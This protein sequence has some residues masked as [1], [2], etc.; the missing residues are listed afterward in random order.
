[1]A[2]QKTKSGFEFELDINRID[3]YELLEAVSE[4]EEDPLAVVRVLKML[5]GKEDV[6]R[7]KEHLRNEDGI[8]P[9]GEL[10]NE[11]QDMFQSQV[12]TKNS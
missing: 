10:I 7:L 11:I 2:K 6:K 8:V 4:V 12:E 1:M 9:A 3:N 5:L